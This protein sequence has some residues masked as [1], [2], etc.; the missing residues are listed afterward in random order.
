MNPFS[1]RA[2]F[3][4]VLY[5]KDQPPNRSSDLTDVLLAPD[6][7]VAISLGDQV[8]DEAAVG[9]E[10]DVKRGRVAVASLGIGAEGGIRSAIGTTEGSASRSYLSSTGPGDQSSVVVLD[11]SEA[12]ARFDATLLSSAD[13]TPAGG[14]TEQAQGG[15]SA[16]SYPVTGSGA[17][18]VEIAS[19]G[20][21]VIAAR[22]IAG[23]TAD[24]GSTAGAMAAATAW[25]VL[26]TVACDLNAPGLVLVDPASSDVTATLHAL[27]DGEG[28]SPK[29]ATVDVTTTHAVGAPA[30]FL[31]VDPTA[32]VLVTSSSEPIFATGA[33]TS[34]G[35][36]GIAGFAVA[37]GI[38]VPSF[39]R[40][41]A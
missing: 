7:S 17:S 18:S 34:C 33:S 26:P 11:P 12:Q 8:L 6:R 20:T 21:P 5:S 24:P 22:R 23:P 41:P 28:P 35:Q 9:A 15:Q 25:V 3:D 16:V 30:R 39:A 13:P 36:Q 10:V 32:A 19:S 40:P 29:D 31:S 1:A 38:P 27:P 2:V 37:S 4:V 14:L